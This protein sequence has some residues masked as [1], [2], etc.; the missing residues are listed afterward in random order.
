MFYR[1]QHHTEM[2]ERDTGTSGDV[3]SKQ[4]TLG[5]VEQES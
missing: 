3:Q 2:Y 1:Q 4:Q 5:Y